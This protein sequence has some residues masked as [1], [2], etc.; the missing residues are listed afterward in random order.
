MSVETLLF[1]DVCL[2]SE[3]FLGVA[4]VYLVLHCSFLAINKKYPLIQI[5]VLNLGVL[6]LFLSVWLLI[7]DG[8]DVLNISIFNNTIS[9]DYLSLSGKFII[10]ILSLCCLLMFKSY[11]LSQRFNNFEYV[12]L[13]LFSVL[14]LFVLCAAND[15]ITAY[16]AIELQSLAFY[17]LAAFKKNSSFSI[18]AGLKYFILGSFASGL[19]LFGSSLLYGITG[20]INFE[21]FKDL[22]F[23]IKPGCSNSILVDSIEVENFLELSYLNLVMENFKYDLSLYL[24][25]NS[26]IFLLF[27]S[28]MEG[29]CNI[30]N[31]ADVLFYFIFLVEKVRFILFYLFFYFK[32]FDLGFSV[33]EFYNSTGDIHSEIVNSKFLTILSICDIAEIYLINP[34]FSEISLNVE[35]IK[36]ALLF[37][38]IS[39]C[40]K[41]AIAPFHMWSPDVY[42]SS[43]SSS[44]FFF[45]VVP[46]LAIFLLILRIFY[47]SFYGFVDS[48]KYILSGMILLSVIIG[49]FG[50]VFQRKLKSL[51]VYSSISHMGYTLIAFSSGSFDNIQMLFCYL[52]VY[53]FSGLCVWSIFMLTRVKQDRLLK[54]NKDLTDLV[55]L[56]KSNY[57][58]AIFFV[59]VLFSI[60]G[61]PP[62]IGFLVKINIFLTAVESS[63]YFVAAISIFCSVIATFYYIRIVKILYFEKLLVG[64]LYY[65]SDSGS[66]IILAFLFWFVLFLFMNPNLLFLISYKFGLLFPSSL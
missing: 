62:L 1:K 26:E 16:L 12:L 50:G 54:Q 42:E 61:F 48:W 46:K 34:F 33:L 38:L 64:R 11:L 58:L 37:I 65:P 14:G 7:N 63:M 4:I 2:F 31:S 27:P 18:D 66:V 40:F 3:L 19:F 45:S 53:S 8:L 44:T 22:L 39:L 28:L 55:L 59:L 51:L 15:L 57:T 5:S 60:A 35:L 9:N 49:S 32:N 10:G 17:V 6:I 56:G 47:F 41:L 30:E 43:P 25:N 23:Y 36:F 20:T 13:I 24:V 52:V 29:G 21:E